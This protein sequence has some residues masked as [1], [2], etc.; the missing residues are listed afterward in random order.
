MY[1]LVYAQASQY[2]ECYTCSG[3]DTDA[4]NP[5][6]EIGFDPVKLNATIV[7]CASPGAACVKSKEKLTRP[8]TTS[9][10]NSNSK[11]SENTF[12]LKKWNA[13]AMWSWDVECDTCAICRVQ[14]M[15]WCLRCQGDNKQEECVVVWVIVITHFTTAACHCG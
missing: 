13:V 12:T 7:Q 10:D 14:V 9:S 6:P 15:D 1:V 2:V 8:E 3:V 4:N 5:C 11:N